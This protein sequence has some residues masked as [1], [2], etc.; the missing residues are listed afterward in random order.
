LKKFHRMSFSSVNCNAR[1]STALGVDEASGR[2]KVSVRTK[3]TPARA[4]W[5]KSYNYC[6][7]PMHAF[8]HSGRRKGERARRPCRPGSLAPAWHASRL[9]IN[10]PSAPSRH[11]LLVPACRQARH[12][13]AGLLPGSWSYRNL[14]VTPARGEPDPLP[15]PNR[16]LSPKNIFSIFRQLNFN[17]VALSLRAPLDWF[18]SYIRSEHLE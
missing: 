11:Q 1:R 9:A 6:N 8:R 15:H 4:G 14:V 3:P 17:R 2:R 13:G 7:S 10:L 18:W 5:Q 16:F 12:R